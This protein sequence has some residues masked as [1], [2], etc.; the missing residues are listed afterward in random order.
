ML[1]HIFYLNEQGRRK[2]IE[3]S[4]FPHP[5]KASLNNRVFLVCDGV[6]GENKGEEAS[7]IVCET[8]GSYLEKRD[9][10]TT[11][12]LK[13][14]LEKTIF[15]LNLF[16]SR[17]PEARHMSTTL[18]LVF[19]QNDGI[20]VAWCGDSRVYHVREGLVRWHTR[21]H[22]LVQQLIDSGEISEQEARTHP[23]RNIILRSINPDSHKNDI[24]IHWLSKVKS[25]DYLLLCTDG[26]LEN[27][28][29]HELGHILGIDQREPDKSSLFRRY[30]EGRTNDNYS[31]YLLQL[32]HASRPVSIRNLRL[33]AL[34]WVLPALLLGA[35][36]I[37]YYD[38]RSAGH[39]KPPSV[40]KTTEPSM[41][42]T[43][44]GVPIPQIKEKPSGNT[45]PRYKP[46]SESADK[47]RADS[48]RYSRIQ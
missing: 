7:R 18:T 13:E 34:W 19:I 2:N 26:L 45:R 24:E 47:K 29:I 37:L 3:D 22:S 32:K 23:R 39:K 11:S 40:Q 35:A 46:V 5:E 36:V 1:K 16:V 21:D 38:K 10:I 9:R 33:K 43:G 25:G 4:L 8:V 31:M 30:C 28:G 42:P 27:I 6:G 48:L 14:A 12:D 44:A 41:A 17:Y 15:E 20:W